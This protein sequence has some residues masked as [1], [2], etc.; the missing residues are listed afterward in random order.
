MRYTG[1]SLLLGI[2]VLVSTGV[3]GAQAD[4]PAAFPE[5][6]T[7]ASDGGSIEAVLTGV[8][9]DAAWRSTLD[10]HPGA[11]RLAVEYESDEG[12][13]VEALLAASLQL[14]NVTA[15]RAEVVTEL[16]GTAD[17]LDAALEEE[18]GR[19]IER[20]RTEA[21]F[22]GMHALTQAA[23]VHV[24]AG[25]DHQIDAVLGLDGAALTEVQR[26]IL[27]TNAT[28]DELF[29][30]RRI[31]EGEFVAAVDALDAA[32]AHRE[33]MEVRHGE[34][35]D[36]SA[37]LAADRRALDDLARELL[38]PAA[39]AYSLS[40]IPG[41]TSLSPRALSAYLNAE[42][43][44][45]ELVPRCH[46]SWRTIA[47]I[48]F[49][50]GK[51]GEH[52]DRRLGVDG[53]PGDPIIG[54]ALDGQTVDNYGLVTANLADTDGG[55]YDGDPRHD[56]AVG[57]MQFIPQ[58]WE[59]WKIDADQDGEFDPQDIDDAAA[60]AGAYLCNYGSLRYWDT[61]STAIFG[62]N[63][64]GAY[65]NS[66]KDALD[67][68]LRF[69]LPAFDGDEDLRQRI[70]YGTWVPLPVEEP[71]DPNAPADEQPPVP[72]SEDAE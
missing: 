38:P 26:E 19:E 49:I 66:V 64:A 27:L 51:H 47:A 72:L 28:L 6:E 10:L 63:H 65:V 3:V 34:L 32:V 13:L 56:R 70:P 62:Y 48:G 41:Q 55:R 36:E 25:T 8:G 58:T 31:A 16:R 40:E 42:A 54:I 22:D 14:S 44:M 59:S 53:R 35:V 69:R 24:F 11:R 68:N 18:R 37:A 12:Q 29:E 4:A 46:V 30:M 39:A 9:L 50:E 15:Q 45:T 60:S 71:V 2:F 57:P 1:L 7:L 23:A 20:N 67:R 43:L 21:H 17:R 52:G 33:L 5:V 61:W